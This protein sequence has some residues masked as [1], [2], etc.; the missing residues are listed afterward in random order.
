MSYFIKSSNQLSV[1]HD[2]LK[3]VSQLYTA[4]SKLNKD[5]KNTAML[6]DKLIEQMESNE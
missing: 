4:L 3:S 2:L 1:S 5:H 6:I